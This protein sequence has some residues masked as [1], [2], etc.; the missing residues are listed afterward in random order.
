MSSSAYFRSTEVF[1][2]VEDDNSSDCLDQMKSLQREFYTIVIQMCAKLQ[3]S[4]EI[5]FFC[6]DSFEVY[7]ENLFKNLATTAMQRMHGRGVENSSKLQQLSSVVVDEIAMELEKDTL[8]RVLALISVAA[9][10]IDG[11]QWMAE[12][13]FM[14]DLLHRNDT[15]Y[16]FKEMMRAEYE[17]FRNVGFIVSTESVFMLSEDSTGGVV[18]DLESVV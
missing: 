2:P 6:L 15:P 1:S 3:L 18:L 13:R 9:K 14:H 17:A 7:M 4:P 8:L 12:F 5:E 10:F 16:T 11:R